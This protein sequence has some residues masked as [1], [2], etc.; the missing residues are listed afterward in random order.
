VDA[1]AV[2]PAPTAATLVAAGF[3]RQLASGTLVWDPKRVS[4]LQHPCDDDCDLLYKVP[5]VFIQ[6]STPTPVNRFG[7]LEPHRRG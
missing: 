1:V 2:I 5:G 4:L 6:R 3:I 7:E